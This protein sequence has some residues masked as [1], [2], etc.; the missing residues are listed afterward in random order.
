MEQ[1]EK[2][3]SEIPPL[4]TPKK[5]GIVAKALP[6]LIATVIIT[7]LWFTHTYQTEH[8]LYQAHPYDRAILQIASDFSAPE[9][10]DKIS[11]TSNMLASEFSAGTRSH[12]LQANCY[13][14]SALKT[15]DTALCQKIKRP[16]IMTGIPV[17]MLAD[18]KECSNTLANP[19]LVNAE[20]ANLHI[21]TIMPEQLFTDIGYTTEL[22][23]TFFANM[24]EPTRAKY[25]PDMKNAANL[26]QSF[27]VYLQDSKDNNLRQNFVAQVRNLQKS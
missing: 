20:I 2:P 19:Q 12:L 3:E 23:K 14:L 13:Y 18:T 24:D 10:C 22:L 15:G 16:F 4:P 26:A 21:E 5:K 25:H 6:F 17:T 7:G 8:I 1:V 11:P 9:L 27:Y